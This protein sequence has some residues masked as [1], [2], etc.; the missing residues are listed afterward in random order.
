MDKNLQE[1]IRTMVKD[2][3]REKLTTELGHI[4]I[5]IK[6]T[7]SLLEDLK[8]KLSQLEVRVKNLGVMI[9]EAEEKTGK[10]PF[11]DET[12]TERGKTTL[13]GSTSGKD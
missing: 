1:E 8:I 9:M 3:V 13:G 6:R 4:R 2:V 7:D 12:V 10:L 11:A 5:L